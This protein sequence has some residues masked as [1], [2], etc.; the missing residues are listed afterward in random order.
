VTIPSL[1]RRLGWWPRDRWR[2]LELAAV[3]VA[4]LVLAV[5]SCSRSPGSASQQPASHAPAAAPSGNAGPRVVPGVPGI[6]R[7]CLEA[8]AACPMVEGLPAISADG[9]LVAV[10]DMERAGERE[11]RPLTVRIFDA[12]SGK[13]LSELPVIT[14]R[15]Y[16]E[17]A[18][19][20]TAELHPATR[21]AVEERV[22]AVEREL[23]RGRY[24]PLTALGT[25]HE[26][27]AGQEI[28][29]LRASFDGHELAVVD[30]G[31]G[32]GQARWRRA[33]GPEDGDA[34]VASDI[35]CEPAPVAEVSVWASREAGVVV[36]HVS[37]MGSDA[38]DSQA[39]FLVWR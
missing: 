23:A 37:Y 35:D 5:A 28:D 3:L 26:Q 39:A 29:G 18:D 27:R 21:T 6:R 34:P 19:P 11:E 1:L 9:T 13:A 38:C 15:D 20:M 32:T 24:R 36:A 33:I 25:V 10:P 17:G 30:T 14:Y 12:G 31:T 4:A 7:E 2:A 22:V 16:D 8:Y